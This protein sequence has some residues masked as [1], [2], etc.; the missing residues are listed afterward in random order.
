VKQVQRLD[1]S[2]LGIFLKGGPI[3][4]LLLLAA[5]LSFATPHF[6]TAR[7]FVNVARQSSINVIVAVGM[8]MIIV[9]GGIDLSVGAITAL[10]ATVAAVAMTYQGL[11]A[12]IGILLGL[13]VGTATG[14]VNGLVITKGK[15]PDFIATLGM[16]STAR[17]IALIIS[18]GLPVPSYLA[19]TSGKAYLPE[20]II[21]IGSG[22][23]WGI[24]MSA[25][26][27][28]LVAVIGWVILSHTTLGRSL[29][30]IGGN[31]EASRVSGINIQWSKIAAYTISGAMCAISG[32][33]LM[34][35]LN[36][37]NALM[38][39]GAEMQA[40]AAVVIGGANLYG[41][42]G[43]VGGTIVGAI[44]MGILSNGLNLLNVSAFWQRVI[45]GLVIVTVVVFDQWRRRISEGA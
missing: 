26:V 10:S 9:S 27:A 35:R 20:S 4:A 23:I 21:W 5:Y 30:A 3:I 31:Q 33:V 28:A 18:G 12:W 40:I 45:M 34:G 44:I 42:D 7:N 39:E 43:G 13:L 14:L 15:I 16:M 6:F 36:S 24:P 17:G 19:V 8:T 32:I 37:A 41:G 25:I 2:R 38:G 1:T 11:S 22:D 29:Y